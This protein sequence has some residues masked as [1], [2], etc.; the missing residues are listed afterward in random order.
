MRIRRRFSLN[1]EER[2]GNNPYISRTPVTD[3]PLMESDE[4]V[5]EDGENSELNFFLLYRV[6]AF[7]DAVEVS[8]PTD[9]QYAPV[10]KP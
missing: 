4:I 2:P 6:H 9:E 1:P 7:H 10:E 3:F 8:I 5:F